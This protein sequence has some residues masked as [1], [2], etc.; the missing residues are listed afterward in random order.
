MQFRKWLSRLREAYIPH[1]R[2]SSP[3]AKIEIL[4]QKWLGPGEAIR[5]I[6]IDCNGQSHRLALWTAKSGGQIV[7]LEHAGQQAEK[8]IEAAC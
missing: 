7:E 1:S 2:N 6:E 5:V 4:G 8:S 3:V